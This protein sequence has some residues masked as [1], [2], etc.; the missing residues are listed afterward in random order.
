MENNI[1]VVDLFFAITFIFLTKNQKQKDQHCV[2]CF[3]ISIIYTLIDH[4][5]QPIS[6]R[7]FAQLL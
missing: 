6:I 3:V 4:S 5:S 1:I 2:T 7:G